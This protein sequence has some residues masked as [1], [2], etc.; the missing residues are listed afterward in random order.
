MKLGHG[1]A[2][3]IHRDF[4]PERALL[5]LTHHREDGA[6][7]H[8]FAEDHAFLALGHFNEGRLGTEILHVEPGHFA[9]TGR[10]AVFTGRRFHGTKQSANAAVARNNLE[11]TRH[12]P[13]SDGLGT[14]GVNPGIL[15][16]IHIEFDLS[17]KRTVFVLTVHRELVAG[18][19]L[20]TENHPFL[21]LFNFHTGRRVT[22]E[23]EGQLGH[24][25][26]TRVT[27]LVL[28]WVM[29]KETAHNPC[30][31]RRIPVG[32][33]SRGKKVHGH[34]A[35][36]GRYGEFDGL[37]VPFRAVQTGENVVEHFGFAA[38][39]DLGHVRALV[40]HAAD[41]NGY[42]GFAVGGRRGKCEGLRDH[43]IE[44]RHKT[45][46]RQVEAVPNVQMRAGTVV[47]D[48]HDACA[49]RSE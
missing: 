25:T 35:H 5:V 21:L 45:P 16:R 32:A 39:R 29:D 43:G 40:A 28:G 4:R 12:K 6:R 24:L 36:A 41:D 11:I 3:G 20:T 2:I 44:R 10:T 31:G 48:D 30:H 7:L 47:I 33:V 18:E 38:H 34:V 27:L 46:V 8:G 17:S 14:T 9:V 22:Q 49:C 26:F 19:C 15:Q 13:R 23:F 1:E 37:G 42:L